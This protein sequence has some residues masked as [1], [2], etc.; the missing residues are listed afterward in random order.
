MDALIA[1]RL[2]INRERGGICGG[3]IASHL[4]AFHG[5]VPHRL[6]IQ[7]PL[8]RLD[9][10]SMVQHKFLLPQANQDSLVFEITFSRNLVGE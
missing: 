4:L 9:F 5:V 3:L 8:G 1:S 7:F 10:N 6:D 2:T